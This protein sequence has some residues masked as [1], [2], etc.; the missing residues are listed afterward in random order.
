ME[1]KISGRVVGISTGHARVRVLV[2]VGAPAPRGADL[3]WSLDGAL[4][5]V[6]VLKRS[7]KL[8]LAQRALE[9]GFPVG[10]YMKD[11]N[12]VDMMVGTPDT[13]TL[14]LESVEIWGGGT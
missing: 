13:V 9:G 10:I 6:E 14:W 8:A 12:V 2:D 1:E 3:Y 7:S 4:D 5:E 11:E